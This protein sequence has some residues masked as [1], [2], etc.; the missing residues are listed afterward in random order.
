MTSFESTV[1]KQIYLSETHYH[2]LEN[3]IKFIILKPLYRILIKY[4][5]N[6]AAKFQAS[7]LDQ[8]R[9]TQG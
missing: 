4:S 1:L 7:P 9:F 8:T 3:V 6:R 5:A 2:F